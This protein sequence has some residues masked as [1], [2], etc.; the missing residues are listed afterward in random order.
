MITLQRYADET[1]HPDYKQ[2]L[3]AIDEA[4]DA[5]G[6]A[7]V[8]KPECCGKPVE[9]RSMIGSVYHVECEICG[10]FAFNVTGPKFSDTGSS[11]SFLDGNKVDLDTQKVWIT[12]IKP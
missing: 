7:Q 9:M 1:V 8:D 6:W 2:P 4:L 5:L 10:K 11:V 3:K 12:G